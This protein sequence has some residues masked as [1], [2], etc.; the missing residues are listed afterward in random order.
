MLHG[1]NNPNSVSDC[2]LDFLYIRDWKLMNKSWI[3][4]KQVINPTNSDRGVLL[5]IDVSN[6]T[7][8]PNISIVMNRL[9][10]PIVDMICQFT[11]I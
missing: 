1:I 4:L 6:T 3:N 8:C 5:I 9:L 7:D 11:T 2:G 10:I